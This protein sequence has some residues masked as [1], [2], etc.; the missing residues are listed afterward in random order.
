MAG[1]SDWRK[2]V[3]EVGMVD[4]LLKWVD[5]E[6]VGEGNYGFLRFRVRRRYEFGCEG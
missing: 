4:V 3:V 1:T 2:M 6:I 5:K